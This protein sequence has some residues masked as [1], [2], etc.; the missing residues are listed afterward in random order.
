MSKGDLVEIEGTITEA[1]GGGFYN[2]QVKDSDAT[3]RA[4][5]SGK[6][7]QRRIRS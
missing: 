7:K 5:L 6:M 4:K 1:I 3:L 2:I